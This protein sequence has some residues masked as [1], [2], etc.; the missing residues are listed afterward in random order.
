MLDSTDTQPNRKA[1][2]S[3]LAKAA[4][5]ALAQRFDALKDIP[6]FKWLRAPEIGA[7]MVRGRAGGSGA[8]FNMGEMTVTRCSLQLPDGTVGHAY[9][10]GRDRE[11]ARRAA[12]CDALMQG[13]RATEIQTQ[14]I[15]PLKAAYTS[16]QAQ[17]AIEAEKTRV[18]FFT[19]VR[20][21]N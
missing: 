1:W 6:D 13:A 20:G 4:P 9:I 16:A 7:V 10:P 14:I 11:H 15:D 3:V 2:M 8:P 21:H 19:M 5:D 17:T 12:V 18:D